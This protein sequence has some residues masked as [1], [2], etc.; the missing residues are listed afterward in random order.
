MLRRKFGQRFELPRYSGE[1]YFRPGFA[2]ARFI[3]SAYRVSRKTP[4]KKSARVQPAVPGS[5]VRL[6]GVLS[7]CLVSAQRARNL[8]MARSAAAGG[9]PQAG[10]GTRSRSEGASL[11]TE[12]EPG[13]G[14]PIG[15]ARRHPISSHHLSVCLF[16]DGG[17]SSLSITSVGIPQRSTRLDPTATRFN[18]PPGLN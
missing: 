11:K 13:A 12:L 3:F 18:S 4:R 2:A 9:N 16:G 7:L 10:R 1:G 6:F 8:A 15:A 17:R 14:I 5:S